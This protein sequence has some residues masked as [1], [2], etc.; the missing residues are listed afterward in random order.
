MKYAIVTSADKKYLPGVKA[1]Y[2]SCI[3]NTKPVDFYLF[4]HGKEEDFKEV[5]GRG[6]KILYNKDTIASPTSSEWREEIPAMYSRLLIPRILSDYDRVLWLDADVLVLKDLTELFSIDMESHAVAGQIA[7][8]PDSPYDKFNFMPYQF[9]EP[10][11]FPEYKNVY[12]IQ[13]GV[14]LFDVKNWQK[15][16]YD[17]AIDAALTSGIKFKFVVQGLLGYVLKGDFKYIPNKWNAKLSTITD[18]SQASV[19]HYVGGAGQNPW[20]TRMKFGD[21]WQEYYR[22]F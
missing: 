1:L 18:P 15:T 22:R 11:K 20:E 5:E 10:S 13:A 19:L 4:A 9:E 14:I 3:K 2:A 17:A 7:H 12:A 21:L 8:R 16:D 6:I